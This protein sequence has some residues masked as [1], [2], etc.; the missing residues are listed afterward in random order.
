MIFDQKSLDFDPTPAIGAATAITKAG[1]QLAA[2]MALG[3]ASFATAGAPPEGVSGA[4][5]S[6]TQ[7]VNQ[8]KMRMQE[9]ALAERKDARTQA[10]SLLA[11]LLKRFESGVPLDAA[12]ITQ[13]KNELDSVLHQYEGRLAAT[14]VPE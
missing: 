6:D 12:G 1:L 9:S 3:K 10:L 13:A 7:F 5:A 8:A 11:D 2:A 14:E 4:Q